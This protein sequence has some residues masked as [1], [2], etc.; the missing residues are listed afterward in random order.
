D[1]RPSILVEA[2][3]GPGDVLDVNGGD[4]LAVLLDPRPRIVTTAHHRGATHLPAYVGSGRQDVI[5]RHRAVRKLLELE[6]MVV[7]GKAVACFLRRFADLG[8]TRAE[9][10]PAGGV[11]RPL[12][13]QQVRADQQCDAE[14]VC[15]P[16]HTVEI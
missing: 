16:A 9:A 12:F 5:L 3:T 7:P 6:I 8:Q 4:A 15:G 2:L 10:A 1:I 13:G 14:R 11:G